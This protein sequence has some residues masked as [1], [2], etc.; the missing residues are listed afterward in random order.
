M[1]IQCT[2]IQVTTP[3]VHLKPTIFDINTY[4]GGMN[5]FRLSKFLIFLNKK[6]TIFPIV[7]STHFQE[8]IKFIEMGIGI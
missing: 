3:K 2:L 6:K 8:F 4:R 7:N 1:F 5:E